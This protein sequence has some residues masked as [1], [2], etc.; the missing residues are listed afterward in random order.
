[1]NTFPEMGVFQVTIKGHGSKN[2]GIP[3][4]HRRKE[5]GN[6]VA[7]GDGRTGRII[8]LNEE[9]GNEF[10]NTLVAMN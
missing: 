10:G 8:L 7:D 4:S 6:R 1:M 2:T 9:A 3:R 5:R